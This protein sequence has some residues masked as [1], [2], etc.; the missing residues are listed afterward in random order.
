MVKSILDAIW[1]KQEF[2]LWNRKNCFTPVH[3]LKALMRDL[4]KNERTFSQYEVFDS[5]CVPLNQHEFANLILKQSGLKQPTHLK[6]VSYTLM[7]KRTTELRH[8][9]RVSK[10]TPP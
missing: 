7:G 9:D 5:G 2:E 8:D 3:R 4:A 1:G 10:F 6:F